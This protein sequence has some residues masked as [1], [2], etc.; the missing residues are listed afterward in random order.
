[1]AEIVIGGDVCPINRNLPLFLKGDA[2]GIFN[3]LLPE[4]HAAD[5]SIVNLECPLIA[6]P[7]PI[8][9][10]GPVLGADRA[11]VTGLT[12]SGIRIA[13][14]ANN[15]ILDHGPAGV[16]STL[17]ACA[18]AGIATVGA[19]ADLRQAGEML[20][21]NAAGVR[22]GILSYAEREFSIAGRD[23]PGANP[24]ELAAFFRSIRAHRSEFDYLIVLVHGGMEH[25][26]LPSPRLQDTC[27]LLVEEGAHAVI[28]QHSHCPGCCESYRGGHIVYG[29]GNLIF[30][31]YPD[32]GEEFY[33][34]YLVKLSLTP[35]QGA[36]LAL[37]PYRQ[38]DA[39]A[40]ARRMQ[41][42]EAESFLG[43]VQK[44]SEQVADPA[45]VMQNWQSICRKK[46]NSVFSVL[47]GHSRVLRCL[48]RLAPFVDKLYGEQNLLNLHNLVRCES[49]RE[50]L[51]TLLAELQ[52]KQGKGG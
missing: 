46:K 10:S 29:Q 3:D 34:G 1:M 33:R 16:L 12:S 20:V 21:R 30:D 8:R 50:V 52:K 26:P 6:K 27:R 45:C 35:G 13:N 19:G 15:H 7:S 40:G 47:R 17:E 28:C 23:S 48:N 38:S 9:K 22:V 42:P 31:R 24:L 41:P 2:Q 14:L 39:R 18:A 43:E 25:Y 37:V 32:R 36:G 49:H 5:L 51:E 44:R 11:A 4:F